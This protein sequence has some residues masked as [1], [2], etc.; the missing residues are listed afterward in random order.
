MNFILLIIALLFPSIAFARPPVLAQPQLCHDNEIVVALQ[1]GHPGT[2]RA[3]NLRQRA[4][5][6]RAIATLPVRVESL[7]IGRVYGNGLNSVVAGLAQSYAGS[8]GAVRVYTYNSSTTQWSEEALG[9]GIINNVEALAVGDGNNDGKEDIVIG[10]EGRQDMQSSR[11]V[12][13]TY[14]NGWSSE[15][16]SP[17]SWQRDVQ[18][19]E[20][21]DLEGDGQNEVVVLAANWSILPPMPLMEIVV[22]KRIAGQ[23]VPNQI[24][25]NVGAYTRA[26]RM[27][28]ANVDQDL[29]KEIFFGMWSGSSYAD[30]KLYML[31]RVGSAWNAIEMTSHVG[32]VDGLG[33]GDLT[34]DGRNDVIFSGFNTLYLLERTQTGWAQRTLNDHSSAFLFWDAD[35]GDADNDGRL[36]GISAADAELMLT[37]RMQDGSLE[38]HRLTTAPTLIDSAQIADADNQVVDCR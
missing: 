13:F 18:Y 17:P 11:V 3:Y 28:I 7:D 23:W 25:Q 15:I 37:R 26:E 9:Q 22:F 31:D 27:S 14:D 29:E 38:T 4:I 24:A 35:M 2:I 12:L 20:V 6:E 32:V 36:D 1:A 21:T 19:V 33:I 16:V 5:F 30:G 34:G 8:P 10:L